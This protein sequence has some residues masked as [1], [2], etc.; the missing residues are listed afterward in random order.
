MSQNYL[1]NDAFK[2]IC[3]LVNHKAGPPHAYTILQAFLLILLH[4]I[5]GLMSINDHNIRKWA[6]E[7]YFDKAKKKKA[8]CF[9]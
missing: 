8:Y 9:Y 7:L 2:L 3:Q 4:N 6:Q 1:L 5:L